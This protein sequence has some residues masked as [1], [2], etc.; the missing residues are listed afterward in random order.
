MGRS[1]IDDCELCGR[2]RSLTFHH[3]IPATLHTNRWFK[4][5][6]TREELS[7]GTMLCTDCHSAIHRFVSEKE[8]GREWNTVERLRSHPDIGRF[9]RWVSRQQGRNRTAAPADRAGHR[10]GARR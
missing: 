10:A 3:L 4:Q 5:R 1:R 6:Y 7:R 9:V 8:L 2:E